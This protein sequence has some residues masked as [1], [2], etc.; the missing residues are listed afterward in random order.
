MSCNAFTVCKRRLCLWFYGY[1][2]NYIQ[3]YLAIKRSPIGL[4]SKR[5]NVNIQ[6]HQVSAKWTEQLK[7]LCQSTSFSY[8]KVN[9][10]PTYCNVFTIRCPFRSALWV[11]LIQVLLYENKIHLNCSYFAQTVKHRNKWTANIGAHSLEGKNTSPSGYIDT[12]YWWIFFKEVLLTVNCTHINSITIVCFLSVISVSASGMW[13]E[14]SRFK[15]CREHFRQ[16][17]G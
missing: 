14:E 6:Y 1:R 4:T 15:F 10:R 7:T 13:S 5:R 12:P 17:I 11:L 16:S 2:L 3:H 8:Q 9:C